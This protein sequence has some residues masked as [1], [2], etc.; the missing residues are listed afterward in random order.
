[1]IPPVNVKVGSRVYTTETLYI[2]AKKPGEIDNY[3]F[4]LRPDRTTCY[5]G[6]KLYISVIWYLANGNVKGPVEFNIP[7]FE[8][9]RVDVVEPPA[10][11]DT[12]REYVTFVIGNQKTF[13]V[14]GSDSLAGKHYQ[15][16]SF[17]KILVPKKTGTISVSEATLSFF[18][19]PGHTIK[20]DI[21]GEPV[22]DK[23]VIPSNKFSLVIKDLPET[24]KPQNYSGLIGDYSVRA[25]AAPVDVRVGDPITLTITLEG[26]GYLDD[27][28]LPP[29]HEM[30]V[31]NKDFKIPRDI[32]PGRVS[33][34]EVVF[35]QT[36]RALNENI[37]AIP[38]IEIPYFNVKTGKYDVLTT[39]PIPVRVQPATSELS[40]TDMEGRDAEASS[41]GEI[42][43]WEEGIAHN[44]EGYD[45]VHPQAYGLGSF[46]R[47]PWILAFIL[48]PV[49]TYLILVYIFRF[50]P[51]VRKDMSAVL[52][53][54]TLDTLYTTLDQGG[55]GVIEKEPSLKEYLSRLMK[56]L[57]A[58][59]GAKLKS[60]GGSLTFTDVEKPLELH[61]VPKDTIMEL[62]KV[63]D[64]C[65]AIHYAGNVFPARDITELGSKTREVVSEIERSFT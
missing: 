1:M 18:G 62:K 57:K 12:N 25:G 15:T 33:G 24:G 43:L 50:S 59:L 34:N 37:A 45:V 60:K 27:A 58:Y 65:E 16:Y 3:K 36:L 39:E 13:A 49:L 61:G 44:Y 35:I 7:L 19:V 31:L 51:L 23:I 32:A 56:E 64:T 4:R 5:M 53:R 2:T 28:K 8:D 47:N 46:L 30:P 42:E 54:K 52:V 21:W 20:R 10:P 6:E 63:F 40:I 9:S 11:T 14:K 22:L 26:D 17:K 29:L 38:A 41:R 48:F 55:A